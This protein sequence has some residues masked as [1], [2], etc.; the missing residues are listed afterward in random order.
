[1]TL[2][3]ETPRLRLRPFEDRDLEPFAAYRSDPNIA[4]YQTWPTPFTHRQAAEFITELKRLQPAT[5]G[6]W[7]QLA[8]ERQ[9]EPGLIGDCAFVVMSHDHQQSEIGFSLAA[10]FQGKGYG[11]E[12]VSRLLKYLFEDL[13]LHRVVAA[14][15]A[16]NAPSYK[17]MERVGM[18]REGHF[19]E[20]IFSKGVWTSEY[21]Y[22]LLKRE[23]EA[24]TSNV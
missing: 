13:N 7:Y 4:R 2:I 8:I 12:A 22:A 20:N 24:C 16:D 18:R 14:C 21:T 1:M 11:A 5:P 3:L 9:E 15:D 19:I 17:L 10:G 23:W 6:E